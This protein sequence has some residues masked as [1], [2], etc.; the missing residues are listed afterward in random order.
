[1]GRFLHH[2]L[3]RIRHSYRK[4]S[5]VKNRNISPEYLAKVDGFDTNRYNR[6]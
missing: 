2:H 6:A 1:M 3:Q 5:S 4:Q